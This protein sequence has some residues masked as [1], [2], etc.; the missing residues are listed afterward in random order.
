MNDTMV[1]AQE[2]DKASQ[3]SKSGKTESSPSAADRFSNI[4]LG[5]LADDLGKLGLDKGAA[6]KPCDQPDQELPDLGSGPPNE[7]RP[8]VRNLRSWLNRNIKVEISD[9]RFLVGTFLCT[10]RDSNVIIG[11][12]N[13]YTRDPDDVSNRLAPEGENAS[14]AS[15][16]QQEEGRIL[17]LAMVPGRHIKKLYIDESPFIPTN[18][19]AHNNS[20]SADSC[21][22]T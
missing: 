18:T 9:G 19:R 3:S 16:P 4:E 17:G 13:E 11:L 7:T 22:S 14:G 21:H 6:C 8:G 1:N 12:C 2:T 15:Q 10:D 5:N 20:G